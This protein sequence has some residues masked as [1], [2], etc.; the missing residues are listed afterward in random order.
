VSKSVPC[1]NYFNVIFYIF[2]NHKI[3]ID[4]IIPNFVINKSFSNGQQETKGVKTLLGDPK[5]AIIKLAIPMIIAMSVQTIY[6]FVDT[7]FISGIGQ[8]LFTDSKI[9]GIGDLGVAAIGLIFPFFMM[10]IAISTGIGVGASSAI[11]RRIGAN[12]KK[13]ADNVAEHSIILALIIALFFSIIL[14]IFSEPLLK[15]I[16]AGEALPYAVSYGR[17]IFAGS[18]TIFF[19]NIATAILR[20]E[21]DVKRV[22]YAIIFGATLNIVLDPIFIYTLKLGVPGAAYATILS[23]L[24]SS[25]IL[26]YWLL[27]KKDTYVDFKLKNFKFKKDIIFDIFKV[28]LPASIQQLSMSFTMLVINVIIIHVALVGVLGISIY[29]IGWRVVMVAILPLLGLATAIVSV[30]GAA[31]GAKEYKKLNTAFLFSIKFGL[32]IEIIIAVIFFVIAPSVTLIFTT[33]EGLP[34]LRSDIELFIKISCLFYPGAAFGIAS[35]AMFQGTGKGLYSLIATLL[36]TIIL[37]PIFAVLLCCVFSFGLSGVWWG[38]VVANLIGS[39]VSF[40]W[41]KLYIRGLFIKEKNV[42]YFTKLVN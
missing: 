24:C 25:F 40:T 22:M 38:L 10:A 37:T 13:G 33:G 35:S 30:T 17:I 9:S 27:F 6:N 16:G 42:N 7:L 39:I 26:V 23:M 32:S 3:K 12:D 15:L 8:E 11:S 28:G 41:A 19:I 4:L 5:K 34:K 31:F 1:I 2:Q 29:T 20:G 18:I 21:G 14:F 36:R